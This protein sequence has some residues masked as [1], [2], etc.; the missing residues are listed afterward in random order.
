[1]VVEDYLDVDQP[2]AGQNFVLLS[3]VSPESMIKKKELFMVH[4]FLEEI[5][6]R[7]TVGDKSG[8][9]DNDKSSD[10]ANKGYVFPKK[11]SDFMESFEDFRYKNE[12]NMDK[13]FNSMNN[14]FPFFVG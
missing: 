7:E 6:L 4:K 8:N 1:M 3:F 5:Y 11:F 10:N 9:K 2:I 14:N 12:E 13:D